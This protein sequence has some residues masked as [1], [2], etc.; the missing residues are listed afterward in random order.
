[1]RVFNILGEEVATLV[2]EVEEAGQRSV[3]FD[4]LGLASG[5]YFY[6]LSTGGYVQMKK[7]VLVR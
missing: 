2:D 7:A 3:H 4:G 6:R 5:V 1:L